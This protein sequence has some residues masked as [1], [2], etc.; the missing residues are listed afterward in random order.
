MLKNKIILLI[1]ILLANTS[2]AEKPKIVTSTI[3]LA[4]ITKMITGDLFD[5]N[6]IQ[7]SKGCP[8]HYQMKP[9]DKNK[10]ENANILIYI[11]DNFDNVASLLFAKSKR[12]VIKISDMKS[13]DFIGNNGQKNWHFW[14]S[15]ENILAYENELSG[16]LIK[17]FPEFK[18]K[19][20][21]NKD[22]A[23]AQ[24]LELAKKKNQIL[25]D[26]GELVLLSD[27]LEHLFDKKNPS[28]SWKDST[29]IHRRKSCKSLQT[30]FTCFY[31]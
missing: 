27:S 14:L 10:A 7:T 1:L 5:I 25:K 24:I 26:L 8:H 22:H 12:H 3:P 29:R 18:A 19:I 28:K 9:S 23:E 31:S 30:S 13:L 15:L 21:S 16:I 4:I 11:D 6:I 20:L 2:Y 17:S